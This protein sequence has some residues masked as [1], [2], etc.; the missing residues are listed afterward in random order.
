MTIFSRCFLFAD[1][2][3]YFVTCLRDISLHTAEL[4]I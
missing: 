1:K 2:T 3:V 4:W